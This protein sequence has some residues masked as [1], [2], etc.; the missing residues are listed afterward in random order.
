MEFPYFKVIDF[1]KHQ[2]KER[3]LPW[4]RFGIFNPKDKSSILYPVGLVDSGSDVTIIDYEFAQELGIEIK[5]GKKS[6]I[7][8][9]GGGKIEAWFHE[10]G[11]LI[12]DN[13]NNKPIVYKDLAGFVYER[14]PLTMPQQTAILG[15]IGFFRQLKV[16][17]DYPKSIFIEPK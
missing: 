8:G 5:K 7:F 16:A 12:Q 3:I 17:F 15:T 14:F 10:I 11:F 2:K 1:P 9:V 6:K 4:I 13:N